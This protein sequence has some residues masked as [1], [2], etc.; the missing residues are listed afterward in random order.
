MDVY[1]PGRNGYDSSEDKDKDDDSKG[2]HG[3]LIGDV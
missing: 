1:D 2:T 3:F